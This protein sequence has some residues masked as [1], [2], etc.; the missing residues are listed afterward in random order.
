MAELAERAGAILIGTRWRGMTYTDILTAVNVGNDF[1]QIQ[2]SHNYPGVANNVALTRLILEGDLLAD[3]VFEGVADTSQVFYY[4]ISLGG[5]QGA[6]MMANNPYIEHGV[7]H[8]GGGVWSTLLERSSHWPPLRH[9][10]AIRFLLPQ[11]ARSFT[12]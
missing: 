11:N 2:N 3:P 6:T 12:R 7:L 4:G 8:V 10:S 9:W 1:G 5:I